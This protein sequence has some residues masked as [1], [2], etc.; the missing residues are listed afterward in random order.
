M[1]DDAKNITSLRTVEQSPSAWTPW[2]MFGVIVGAIIIGNLAWSW[3]SLKYLEHEAATAIKALE[4]AEAQAQKEAKEAYYHDMNQAT[5]AKQDQEA[6]NARIAWEHYN[7]EQQR[8]EQNRQ[9]NF[10]LAQQRQ[11]Q[12]QDTKQDSGFSIPKND[13][14]TQAETCKAWK[15]AQLIDPTPQKEKYIKNHC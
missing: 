6:E 10:I 9:H 13:A 15:N 2:A 7:A 14:E 3:L 8:Q 1:N 12:N 11:W 5:L 4:A